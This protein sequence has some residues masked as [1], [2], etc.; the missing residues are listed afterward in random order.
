MTDLSTNE[1]FLLGSLDKKSNWIRHRDFYFDPGSFKRGEE[2]IA[3]GLESKVDLIVLDELGPMELSGNGWS[4]AIQKL[5]KN[6]DLIQIW[7]V[8]DRIVKE[9]KDRWN[10]PDENIYFL[11][12]TTFQE[13]LSGL[14]K[15]KS[16]RA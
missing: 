8:R 1:S 4:N 2:I 11:G 5:E 15:F 13:L 7:V 14:D 9:V 6:Y 16:T 3:K 12:S 10:I